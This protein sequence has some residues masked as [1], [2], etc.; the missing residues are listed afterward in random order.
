MADQLTPEAT[1]IRPDQVETVLSMAARAPSACATQPWLFR[2]T[3]ESIEFYANPGQRSGSLHGC[4]A[5][6]LSCGSA[7]F[8]MRLAVRSLGYVPVVRLLPD[9]DRA[10]LL[11]R[12]RLTGP[13]PLSEGLDEP[14]HIVTAPHSGTAPHSVT[15]PR[16]VT[17]AHGMTTAGGAGGRCAAGQLPIGLVPAMRLD[18]AGERAMLALVGRDQARSLALAPAGEQAWVRLPGGGAS[19]AEPAVSAILLTAAHTTG[20]W[21][22]AGQALHRLLARAAASGVRASLHPVP[23][24]SGQSWARISSQLGLVAGVPQLLVRFEPAQAA[25][26]GLG[27]GAFA[28]TAP[29]SE[30]ESGRC[31]TATKVL[32]SAG[33]TSLARPAVARST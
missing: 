14:A 10:S 19:G 3:R 8:G 26:A 11:A 31:A 18:A 30:N 2:V 4:R 1:R 23:I 28:V 32:R 6:F 15:A 22:R 5:M 16:C 25:R 17:A 20:D 9:P 27:K 24:G 21:L 33:P 7:L 13:V 12:L 29:V